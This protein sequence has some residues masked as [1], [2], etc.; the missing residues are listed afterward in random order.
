MSCRKV[1]SPVNYE[2]GFP[3]YEFAAR[4]QY[5]WLS[6]HILLP[7][8]W[9]WWWRWLRRDSNSGLRML[10]MGNLWWMAIKVPCF[11]STQYSSFLDDFIAY[12]LSCFPYFLHAYDVYCTADIENFIGIGNGLWYF[13]DNQISQLVKETHLLCASSYIN[14]YNMRMR[15]AAWDCT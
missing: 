4:H 9:S 13:Y 10:C 3:E 5:A 15:C 14:T 8:W 1:G 12:P 6:R 11:F 2:F 7:G